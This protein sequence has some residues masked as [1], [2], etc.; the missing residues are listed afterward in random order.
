LNNHRKKIKK[1][2][3]LFRRNIWIIGSS[4]VA[5]AEKRT[6]QRP[7]GKINKKKKK[8]LCL[9]KNGLNVGWAGLP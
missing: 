9:D 6:T 1:K 8:N 2:S 3:G 5:K 7:T 4:I